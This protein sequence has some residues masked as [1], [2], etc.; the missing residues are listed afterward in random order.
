VCSGE[1]EMNEILEEKIELTQS[2]KEFCDYVT[3]SEYFP[4][5]YSE[6]YN[7]HKMFG[8]NLLRRGDGEV[9]G[10]VNSEYFEFA[11]DIFH[12]FCCENNINYTTIFRASFNW[13]ITSSK[14]NVGFHRDHLFEHK[15]F[16]FYMTEVTKGNTLVRLNEKTIEIKPEKNK[17]VIFPGV[18][19]TQEFC[20]IDENRIIMIFTFR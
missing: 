7:K 3:N 1:S 11:K 20:S 17:C 9:P 12:S 14:E 10:I 5:Y 15:I 18:E 19:H 2:Q 16:L 4:W 6:A 13:S 8:H